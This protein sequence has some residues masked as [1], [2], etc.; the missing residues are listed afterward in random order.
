[1]NVSQYQ[2]RISFAVAH[3]LYL[4][5][6]LTTHS[7]SFAGTVSIQLGPPAMLHSAPVSIGDSGPAG[8]L[9][10]PNYV[11]EADVTAGTFRGFSKI[12]SSN[13]D[14]PGFPWAY[15]QTSSP[16]YI[17]N[18]SSSPIVIPFG[19]FR[20]DVL[21][22]YTHIAGFNGSS[23]TSANANLIVNHNGQQHLAG[24]S[25]SLAYSLS[26]G[27]T[28]IVTNFANPAQGGSGAPIIYG[29]NEQGV[30]AS[31]LMP[32]IT[33]N[34]SE[35]LTF[36]TLLTTNAAATGDGLE[37]TIDA[38]YGNNGAR[39]SLILPRGVSL[40]DIQTPEPFNWITVAGP[41]DFNADGRVDGFDFLAWQR[42]ESPNPYSA[43]DL[44]EWRTNYGN[45]GPLQEELAA[46]PE[47]STGLLMVA[48]IALLLT[49]T[50]RPKAVA[51]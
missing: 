20:M 29:F 37:A 21:V 42:G 13:N 23:S 28:T 25:A 48:G 26:G 45:V 2:I 1:M 4:L 27:T 46:V 49:R 19:A 17:L 44:A 47:P 51:S 38:Y 35:S 7:T 33:L 18:V 36:S 32:E 10:G 5:A 8:S 41:G 3:S 12:D 14:L 24:F 9:F 16:Y 22:G 31:L 50:S 6:V 34:P 11:A 40:S 39:L 30:N 15:A 43:A